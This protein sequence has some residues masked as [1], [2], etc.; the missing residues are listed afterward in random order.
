MIS[1]IG[2]KESCVKPALH[3]NHYNHYL[4]AFPCAKGI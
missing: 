4:N 3:Y 1:M 2:L